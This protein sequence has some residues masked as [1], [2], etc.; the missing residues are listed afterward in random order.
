MIPNTVSAIRT[1]GKR[2]DPTMLAAAL[3]GT[4]LTSR[5]AYRI[6]LAGDPTLTHGE[7]AD[8]L[9]RAGITLP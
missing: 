6:A 3:K 2:Q 9:A 8:L 4:T 1:A 5:E 7:W